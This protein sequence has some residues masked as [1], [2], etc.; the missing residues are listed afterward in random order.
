MDTTAIFYSHENSGGYYRVS[1]FFVAK[2]MTDL[3]PL[4]MIPLL[5]FSAI[6]YFMIG[7]ISHMLLFIL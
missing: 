4:R 5:P 6:T 7:K 1:A 3:V 2:V